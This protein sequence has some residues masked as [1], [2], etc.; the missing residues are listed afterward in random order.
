MFTDETVIG[1]FNFKGK[2]II[3][4]RNRYGRYYISV[5]D[6]VTQKNLCDYTA[7]EAIRWLV[8][9]MNDCG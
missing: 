1:D 3:I 2:R 5:D 8:N 7:V 9:M 6:N 4:N